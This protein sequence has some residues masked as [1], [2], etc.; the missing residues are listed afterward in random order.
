MIDWYNWF[1]Y[2]D[3]AG[4]RACRAPPALQYEILFIVTCITFDCINP[5][6]LQYDVSPT[7]SNTHRQNILVQ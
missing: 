5:Y 1:F 4:N 7:L 3:V 6:N 2:H